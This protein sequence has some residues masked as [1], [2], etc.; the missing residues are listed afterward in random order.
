MWLTLI[1]GALILLLTWDFGRKRQRV[2]AFEK[3][4]IPGPISIPILGCGLQALH[5]GAESESYN[6][7]LEGHVFGIEIF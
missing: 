3:S 5:L 4:Q 6:I 2:A 1:T 7:L